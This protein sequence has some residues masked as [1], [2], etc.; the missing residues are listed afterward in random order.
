MIKKILPLSHHKKK[1]LL[2]VDLVYQ[3]DQKYFRIVL[4]FSMLFLDL[5]GHCKISKC[6]QLNMFEHVLTC[7]VVLRMKREYFRPRLPM[8]L[9]VSVCT[10]LLIP[11]IDSFGFG[12]YAHQLRSKYRLGLDQY[13][14]AIR[15]ESVS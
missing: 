10:S 5:R 13:R 12:T 6:L 2:N 8:I 1:R 11:S 4:N 14:D 15:P 9:A 7:F 3:K